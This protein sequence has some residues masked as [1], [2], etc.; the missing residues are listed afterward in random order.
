MIER[1]M[2]NFCYKC[3]RIAS[4]KVQLIENLCPDCYIELHPLLTFPAPLKIKLCEKC[5]RYFFKNRWITSHYTDLESI[6]DNSLKDIIP[7]QIERPPQTELEITS[8]VPGNME[9]ILRKQSIIIDINARGRA[10]NTLDIYSESYKSQKVDLIFTV[11]PSCL[12]VKRGMYQAILHILTPDREMLERERDYVFS[13]IEKQVAKSTKLDDLAYIS[14]FNMKKGKIT[15]YVGSEKF[16]RALASNLS[17]NLGGLL[18]ETYKFGSRKIP[19][20]VKQN[21]LYISIYLPSFVEGDLLW[22]NNAPLHIT[23]IRGKKVSG[24]NLITLE[25]FK[26]PLKVLKHATVLL[27]SSD[28]RSFIN[29]SQTKET[30]QLMDLKNY[31]I[32]EIPKSEKYGELKVGEVTRGFEVDGQIHIIP[33]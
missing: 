21:K 25:Q 23:Q 14:K 18:K 10:H 28:I 33:K 9:S 20:E 29:F 11:C 4:E 16:A 22:V 24:H 26:K 6:I 3:G 19:K 31:R 30:F 5:N 27:H 8:N 2:Q 7:P 13:F 32:F 15:F 12:S 1:K 17:Y